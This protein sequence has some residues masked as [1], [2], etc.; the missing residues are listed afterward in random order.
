[1]KVITY[2]RNIGSGQGLE[3]VI[4]MAAKKIRRSLFFRIIGDGGIKTLLKDR[5]KE[6]GVHN[7]E[8]LDPVSREKLIGYYN[9]SDFLFYI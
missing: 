8:L 7:V 3:K 2:A 6:L 9:D 4:P 1:M 5:I